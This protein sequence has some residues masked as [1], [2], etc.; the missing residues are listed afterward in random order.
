MAWGLQWEE[1]CGPEDL[2]SRLAC[3]R[4]EV[5]VPIGRQKG[6]V[7]EMANWTRAFLATW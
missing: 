4:M 3:L 7:D 1:E 6:S 2:A 5:A